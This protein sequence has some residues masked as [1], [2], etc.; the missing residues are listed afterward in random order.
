M[1]EALDASG[2]GRRTDFA[3]DRVNELA[4]QVAHLDD[5][6]TR[7]RRRADEAFLREHERLALRAVLDTIQFELREA[8]LTSL[9]RSESRTV[10]ARTARREGDWAA[11]VQRA[12]HDDTDY[13]AE[14]HDLGV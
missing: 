1:D 2:D 7:E 6:A 9:A 10:D 13:Q 12:R 3:T 14:L 5:P 4:R 11:R 8:L